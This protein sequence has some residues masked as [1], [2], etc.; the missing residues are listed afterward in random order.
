MKEV[1]LIVALSKNNV[2]G[3]KGKLP[4]DVVEDLLWFR[5]N[6]TRHAVVM[7]R[8]TFDSIGSALPRRSNFIVTSNPSAYYDFNGG[9]VP[10]KSLAK[11]LEFASLIN[12]RIFII[13]GAQIYK[14][15]LE[16]GVVNSILLT[17]IDKV[18]EGDTTLD[19][20]SYLDEAL[21]RQ[22]IDT[23]H[24]KFE[25]CAVTFHRY[26]LKPYVPTTGSK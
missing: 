14:E 13:G 16:T 20:E 11:A 10:V 12:D 21:E 26:V 4:W 5:E 15:A 17:R 23:F 6:T 2:I 8:K 9:A 1:I 3:N 19:I 7:G 18:V 22:T 24:S 25:N